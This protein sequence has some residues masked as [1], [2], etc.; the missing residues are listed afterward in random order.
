MTEELVRSLCP[1]WEAEYDEDFSNPSTWRAA[2]DETHYDQL[3]SGEPPIP[4]YERLLGKWYEVRDLV[5]TTDFPLAEMERLPNGEIRF[6]TCHYNGGAGLGE[7]LE[8][9]LKELA[10]PV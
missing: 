10:P 8:S 1:D 2:L 6:D 4:L 7:V 9:A 5:C 3:D